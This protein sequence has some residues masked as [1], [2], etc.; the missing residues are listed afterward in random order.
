[1]GLRTQLQVQRE[2]EYAGVDTNDAAQLSRGAGLRGPSAH[3]FV[4][5]NRATAPVLS[6]EAQKQLFEIVVAPEIINDIRRILTKPDVVDHYG[7]TEWRC[8]RPEIQALLFDLR[9]RGDYTP[10]VREQIQEYVVS[11]NTQGLTA[12]MSDRS[13]WRSRGVTD[14]RIATRLQILGR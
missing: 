7:A 6:Q 11:N 12:V 9:Y 14:A 10:D 13:F 3:S 5:E 2:L 8:L 1:M 4:L